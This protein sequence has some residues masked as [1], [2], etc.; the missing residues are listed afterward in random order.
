MKGGVVCHKLKNPM[1]FGEDER[2][3]RWEELR[4]NLH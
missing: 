3:G 2:K 1:E 4:D